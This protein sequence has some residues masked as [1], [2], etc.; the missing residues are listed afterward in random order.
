M[1]I[2]DLKELV[3]GDEIYLWNY[4]RDLPVLFYVNKIEDEKVF[5]VAK[6]EKDIFENYH[7]VTIS[8]NNP[9]HLQTF[10]ESQEMCQCYFSPLAKTLREDE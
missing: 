3:L 6:T 2:K 4:N 9:E 10:K 7:T 1:K 8:F 5:V